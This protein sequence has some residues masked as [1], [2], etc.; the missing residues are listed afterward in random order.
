MAPV[1]IGI[2][3]GRLAV[4]K[5][6]PSQQWHISVFGSVANL[7]ARLERIAKEFKV[8]IVISAETRDRLMEDDRVESEGRLLRKLC[9]IQPAGF[10]GSYPIYEVVMPREMGGSG[11][12]SEDVAKYE[13]ALD[14]FLSRKWEECIELLETMPEEDFASKWLIRKTQKFQR[15][16]PEEGWSG[17]IKSLVK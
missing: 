12:S 7:G 13:N 2:S 5:T 10:Q 8:P 9:F 1:R 17:N 11:I 6:G 15:N 4:G 14:L 3:T 16:P